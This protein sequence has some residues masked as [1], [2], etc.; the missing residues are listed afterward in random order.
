[1]LYHTQPLELSDPSNM[2][3]VIKTWSASRKTS[4]AQPTSQQEARQNKQMRR[5]HLF[6]Q[7][8]TRSKLSN[9]RI[10]RGRQW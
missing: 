1:V 8:K 5:A 2:L 4:S 9:S 3:N 10:I 6:K 7:I